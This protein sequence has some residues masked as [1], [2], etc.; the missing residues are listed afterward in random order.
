MGSIMASEPQGVTLSPGVIAKFQADPGWP[1][2]VEW[3]RSLD[4]TNNAAIRQFADSGEQPAS[5]E[6]F[7]Q[8][9]DA[10]HASPPPADAE[11]LA[12]QIL[13][14]I[15]PDQH[16][17]RRGVEMPEGESVDDDGPME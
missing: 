9:E 6:L 3:A 17:Q 5:D 10:M 13:R 8:L 14:L 2:F 16:P 12:V 4:A 7:A 11:A 15:A 1:A